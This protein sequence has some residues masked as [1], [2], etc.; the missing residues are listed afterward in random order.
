MNIPEAVKQKLRDLPDQPG[1]YLMRDQLGRIIYVGKAVSL[2][3]RVQ[4]YFRHATFRGAGP[5]LAGLIKSVAN[6]DIIV[7]DNEASALLTEGELIKTYRPHYN[8]LF[9]DDKRFPLLRVDRQ[10]PFPRIKLCRLR[11]EDGADYFGPYVS[12]PAAR[13]AVEFIEKRFGLRKCLAVIPGPTDHT[14]C[15]N[16]VVRFC[17]A[18]CIGKIT[19]AQYQA[20]VTDACAFLN[21]E[22]PEI[23]K[24]LEAAMK[25][26]ADGR[27]F[28]K[29]ASLRDSLALI[30]L[31][32]R[33]RA[34]VTHTPGLKPEDAQAGLQALQN[35]LALPTLPR[36]IEGFDI[37]NISGTHAV[38]SMVAAVDGLPKPALYRRFRI[39]TVQESNDPEM[40]AEVIRRR[41][42]RQTREKAP[43][44]DLVLI[45]GGITQ[46]RAAQREL[47]ALGLAA[48]PAVGLAKQFEEIVR[49]TAEV[50]IS[51]IRLSSDSPALKVLQQLRDEAHRFA[52]TYHRRLRGQRIRESR[53][54]DIPGV[55]EQR[56]RLLLKTFG[57]V[58]RLARASEADLAA[59]PGVGP[60]L[61][62]ALKLQLGRAAAP[63][64]TPTPALTPPSATHPRQ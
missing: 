17:A 6:L 63:A 26:A 32:I 55:G 7:V 9:K 11:R 25:K 54:D 60:A 42:A 19:Q 2:R 4:S 13:A 40:M 5:K 52:L 46:L 23:L 24:E 8:T 53:L 64:P 31:A 36:L 41:Y 18:P 48:L 49:E 44:P 51:N 22:R 3:R 58:S 59:V 28:E 62:H 45:D 1:C 20:R 14:H 30:R 43:L 37:S 38:G 47:D 27:H 21:G 16:D 57:S 34:H 56:K 39:Q 15:I 10:Q 29:A 50:G 33:Q 61:A 12:S 35:E